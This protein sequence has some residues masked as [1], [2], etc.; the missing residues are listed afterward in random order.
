VNARVEF[1]PDFAE[2]LA[3]RVAEQLA[4]VVGAPAEPYLDVDQAAA[5]LA[6]DKDRIYDLKALGRI[7]F[8]KDGRRLLFRREWLDAALKAR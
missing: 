5:Y 4:E 2:E 1:P 6:C 3:R 7:H 8:V